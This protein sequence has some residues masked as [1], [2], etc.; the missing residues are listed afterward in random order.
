VRVALIAGLIGVALLAV[1][2][3]PAAQ[4]ELPIGEDN[5]VRITKARGHIVFTPK[6]AKLW[7]RV[8]GRVIV[9]DCIKFV[10]DGEQGGG[11]GIRVPKRGRRA[12]TDGLATD[13]DYCTLALPARRRGRRDKVVRSIPLTQRGAVY[14]D[15][16]E[17]ARELM[18]FLTIVGFWADERELDGWPTAEQVLARWPRLTGYVFPLSGPEG[19]PPSK[20]LGYWS[21]G[22]AHIAVVELSR[23]GRRLFME[24]EGDVLHTNVSGYIFRDLQ[25]GA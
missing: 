22:A 19:T 21:D 23:S 12:S 25:G 3:T 2:S 14:L 24:Y 15:E 10:P 8:A 13:A 5:G 17:K 20:T 7:R 9:L 4:V 11:A 16:R 1:P 18:S 6:A